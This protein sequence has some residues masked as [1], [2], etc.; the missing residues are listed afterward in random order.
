V[1]SS[2]NALQAGPQPVGEPLGKFFVSHRK[3]VLDILK[4]YWT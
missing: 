4:S 3:I 1:I 2:E